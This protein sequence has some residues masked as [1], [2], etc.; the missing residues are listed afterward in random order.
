[1]G[2]DTHQAQHEQVSTSGPNESERILRCTE[3][4]NDVR[5]RTAEALTA[6]SLDGRLEEAILKLPT[7]TRRE[8]DSS[9]RPGET[10]GIP[11]DCEDGILDDVRNRAAKSLTAACVDGTLERSILEL[12]DIDGK[13]TEVR[14]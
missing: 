14:K 9:S 6:A 2:E 3:L 5:K 8:Q 11:R 4:D 1:M 12:P 13:D 7:P 10:E